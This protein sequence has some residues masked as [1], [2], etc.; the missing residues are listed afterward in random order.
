M[1]ID[2]LFGNEA[3]SIIH[4]LDEGMNISYIPAFLNKSQSD[5]LFS[6][7]LSAVPWRQPEIW[8]FGRKVKIPRLTAWYGDEGA[9]YVYSGIKNE[10][11][12]W[13]ATLQ[14]LRQR[15]EKEVGSRFNSVLLNLYRDGND[16]LSWHSD[17]EKE[18][19][20]EPLIASVSLG[21]ER[22]FSFRSD[23]LNARNNKYDLLLQHGSLV[24]MKGKTQVN[25]LHA[26][27]KNLKVKDARI[28]LTFRLVGSELR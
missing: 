26:M 22:V 25:W 3:D 20:V 13:T 5:L 19:G 21:A 2:D 28:N 4:L 18:L 17:N 1:T 8:M 9:G 14:S 6:E 24:C 11:L 27:K 23:I 7:L 10:P 16:H 15:V 12:Q